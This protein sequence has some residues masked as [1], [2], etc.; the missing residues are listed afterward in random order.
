M[1][2]EIIDF[3]K[4]R[5]PVDCNWRNGNCYWMAVILQQRFGGEICYLPIIGHF[6]VRIKGVF[7]DWNGVVPEK[8]L[9]EDNV[10]A[11]DYIKEFDSLW[12]EHLMRDCRD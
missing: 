9:L 2:E 7:Y 12:Y 3:I 10:M 6:V 4:R 8:I 1:K 11:L 5:F